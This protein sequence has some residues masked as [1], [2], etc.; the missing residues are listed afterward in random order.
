[1]VS[2]I[3]NCST[4]SKKENCLSSDPNCRASHCA[5]KPP[6]RAPFNLSALTSFFFD[7]FLRLLFVSVT[8][9]CSNSLSPPHSLHI[10][11]LSRYKRKQQQRV[12][13]ERPLRHHFVLLSLS[14]CVLVGCLPPMQKSRGESLGEEEEEERKESLAGWRLICRIDKTVGVPAV[15]QYQRHSLS[16]SFFL[17]L[18]L[19]CPSSPSLLVVRA[20]SV[21]V[22]VHDCVRA[23]VISY[24]GFP[25]KALKEDVCSIQHF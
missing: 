13:R 19:R 4:T 7:S 16:S 2:V 6:I 18:F 12:R 11:S 3:C 9:G 20:V 8:N 15:I 5:V 10:T 23:R 14:Y 17:L 25:L 24:Q 21:G 22:C 1:M